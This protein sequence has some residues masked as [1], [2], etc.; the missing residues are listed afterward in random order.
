MEPVPAETWRGRW[1]PLLLLG[2]LGMLLSE[3]C[4]WNVKPLAG[5]VSRPAAAAAAVLAVY[6]GYTAVFAVLADL[7]IR[8]K[9]RDFIGL[10]LLGS[11][12][13]LFNEGVLAD[14]VFVQGL[15]P[16]ILGLHPLN[17]AFIALS[18]H[19]LIDV[20]VGFTALRW[21]LAGRL[22]LSD[23]R[24]SRREVL[25]CLALALWLFAWSRSRIVLGWFPGGIPFGL[26]AFWLGFSMALL[27]ATAWGALVPGARLPAEGLPRAARWLLWAGAAA[28]AVSRLRVLPDPRA[29]I[30]YGAVVLAYWSLF[31][32]YHRDRSAAERSVLEEE[33]PPAAGFL[34]SK[35]LRLCGAVLAGYAALFALDQVVSLDRFF[36]ALDSAL[37]F[38]FVAFAFLFPLAAT[39]A[40]TS[41]LF[42]GSLR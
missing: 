42:N 22:G 28:A 13:G 11:V 32:L 12:Y 9:V 33:V 36:M 27:G 16:R 41:R 2:A 8:Y 29:F 7:A 34:W 25:S 18:W 38:G 17:T 10:V 35:Y 3:A 30:T 19:A 20:C 24:L 39:A 31:V 14:K 26:Q 6:F 4:S 15:G 40:V 37:I 21:A 23:G 1:A 5:L